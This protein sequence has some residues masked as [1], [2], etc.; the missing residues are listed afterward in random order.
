MLHKITWTWKHQ[1]LPT[2]SAGWVI[3]IPPPPPSLSDLITF[4]MHLVLNMKA[5]EAKLE[6]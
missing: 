3:S 2:I 4:R 1:N 6:E 5:E